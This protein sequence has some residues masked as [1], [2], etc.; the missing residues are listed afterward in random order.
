MVLTALLLLAFG[1]G[2]VWLEVKARQH[3][4]ASRA[5]EARAEAALAQR[6]REY[7]DAVLATGAMPP[8][9]DRVRAIADEMGAEVWEI[10]RAPD[11][12]V[13]LHDSQGHG[14]GPL[15][16]VLTRCHRITFRHPA[17]AEPTVQVEP[18]PTCPTVTAVPTPSRSGS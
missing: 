15:P 8:T 16:G 5:G 7:A 1:G 10:H 3:G 11:L 2:A 17:V 12:S 6:A 13:V 14:P 9:D 18:L 4:E